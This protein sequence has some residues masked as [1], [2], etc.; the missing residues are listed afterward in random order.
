M[1]EALVQ[2]RLQHVADRVRDHS[3]QHVNRR[4]AKNID[5]TVQHCIREGREAIVER[6]AEIDREWDIDRV[7]MA[8]FA[9][10]GGA[11]YALGTQR[12]LQGPV[13]G[14]SRRRTRL[15][16]VLGAQLG[17][18]L[19]HATVGWCPPLVV[20]RRMG[21]RTKSEIELER[22]LLLAALEPALPSAEKARHVETSGPQSGQ[23][24]S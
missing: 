9:L 24:V 16:Y 5:V 18:L 23:V 12:L 22:S 15:L 6:L 8:N 4:I 14:F 7:L 1:T 3:P 2:A 11:A 20:L 10:V 19:L 17:F 21:V 13:F